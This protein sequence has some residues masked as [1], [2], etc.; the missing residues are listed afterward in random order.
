MVYKVEHRIGIAT[1]VDKV[2][3]IVA[4]INAWP[5]WSPIHKTASATLSFGAP[6]SLEEV[7]DGL[8][9][10]EQA[11]VIEDWVPLSHIHVTIPKPFYAGRLTRYFELENL[12]ETG[13]LFTVGALFD[14]FLSEREGKRFG[15]PLKRGFEAMGH[16]LKTKAEGA[17]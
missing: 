10:W 16:A 17:S 5:S 2:Y 1:P 13:S 15:A 4:D 9:R 14:G 7:Y 11:G 6:I 8:S 12:S 3:D